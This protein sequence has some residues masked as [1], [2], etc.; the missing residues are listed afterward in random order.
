MERDYAAFNCARREFFK[1]TGI[2]LRPASTGINGGPFPSEHNFCLGFH[3]IQSPGKLE[4]SIMTTPTLNEAWEYGSDFSR[5]MKVVDANKTTLYISG[6][7]S[8]DEKGDTVHVDD[9]ERQVDRMLLNISE[10]L[11]GANASWD[12]VVSAITYLK[13]RDDAPRFLETVRS[14]G[15]DR[16]PHAL[17]EAWVCRPDLLC[18]MEAIALLPR[19]S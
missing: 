19:Q 5:G 1:R 11:E 13:T 16:F 12:D 3:A 9:F 8:V 10:L 7:A 2:E 15:L 14:R 6:T 17:V 18:E 4:T